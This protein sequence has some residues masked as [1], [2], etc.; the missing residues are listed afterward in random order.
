MARRMLID[1]THLEETRVVVIDGNRVE[2]LDFETARRKALKGNV[3]LAKVTRAEPSLQAAFVDYG[4]NR[5]G[6]LAFSEI[7]PDYYRLPIADREALLAEQSA[8]P[9]DGAPE[10]EDAPQAAA[11]AE[12][13]SGEE[14]QDENVE[15]LDEVEQSDEVV[16]RR[17]RLVRRYRIQE[18]IKRRQILLVQVVKE[19]R[20][21]KGAA[22]TTY[23]SL[24]GRYCVL[25]PNTGRGG[26]ISRKIT[27][28]KD[29]KR[30]KAMLDD[31]DTPDGMSVI[32]RTAGQERNKTE[33]RRDFEYLSRVWDGIREE[34]LRSTAPALI[35]E[36]AEIVKR[37]I[38]DVYSR[39]I[40]E[41]VIDGEDA[42]K[43]ARAF[44]RTMIPSHVKRVQKH[45]DPVVPLFRRYGVEGQLDSI[46]SPTVQLRSGGYIVLNP[47]EALV[48][49]DVNSGRATKERNIEETALRTNL[50]AAE[51]VARQ[52]RLRDLAGLIVIDF[53]DMDE[54]RHNAAV[55]R[56]LKDAMR[57]DR[58]RIQ[59]GRISHFGLLEMSRQRMRSSLLETSSEVC[60]ACGGA[61]IV[62]STDSSSLQVLRAI[63]DEGL[64]RPGAELTVTVPGSV[65]MYI[66]NRK[67]SA[68]TQIES[69]YDFTVTIDA[70][71]GMVTPEHRIERA[72]KPTAG[73]TVAEAEEVETVE[74]EA[75]EGRSRRRPRRDAEAEPAAP[76]E[77]AA[78]AEEPGAGEQAEPT[79][80]TTKRRRRG[81]RGGRRHA[82]RAEGAA[83]ATVDEP[84]AD[85]VEQPVPEEAGEAEAGAPGSVA[86]EEA[87]GAPAAKPARA[88]RPRRRTRRAAADVETEAEAGPAA[89]G[90]DRSMEDTP[91]PSEDEP[92]PADIVRAPEAGAPEDEVEPAP[93]PIA[94]APEQPAAEVPDEEP[95]EEPTQPPRR[96]WWQR[97][98]S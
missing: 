93:V 42:Y 46:F 92:A 30:L 7:H 68:L 31:L 66:L 40:E 63:E 34:T 19:E 51:E 67:R 22:L 69:R 24:A 20:G 4:G 75:G 5:H 26:G 86:G 57:Q 88:R 54:R 13:G 83:E 87:E 29:R 84:V 41:I 55:E 73:E 23:L 98:S 1:A 85:A 47:T 2:E 77:E 14:D 95:P 50:E 56:C 44:M 3:Y 80:E 65:A 37:A 94:A 71:P 28:L 39:D 60:P 82:R 81:R 17:H 76:A 43:T 45:D 61:G 18:V 89:N 16:A 6:F 58:A 96:G 62:R 79:E 74:A 27:N 36:E 97:L 32:L 48:S 8:E 38:R 9:E 33:I 64:R 72:A 78:M 15:T 59:I 53:I 49:I 91:L 11:P 21:T 12:A 70:D 52:L 90:G 25:M 35:H 10:A